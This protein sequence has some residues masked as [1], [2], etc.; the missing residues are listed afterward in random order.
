MNNAVDSVEDFG[1]AVPAVYRDLDA[2]AMK[3][4]SD[5]GGRRIA[6]RIW[7]SGEPLVLLHGS[8]GSWTHWV[9]N[10]AALSGRFRVIAPD[11]PGCGDSDMWPT[12]TSVGELAE[13]LTEGLRQ[14]APD[15]MSFRLCGFSFGAQLAGGMAVRLG[16]AARQLII[17]GSGQIGAPR[18]ERRR[19]ISW[20]KA[21]SRAERLEAHRRNLEIL[22]LHNPVK[23]GDDAV[24]YQAHNAQRSRVKTL[25]LSD[26]PPLK[27]YLEQIQCELA[28]IW[29]AQD[30]A[31]KD[32]FDGYR[33][34]LRVHHP[35]VKFVI[36]PGAAHW[37]AYDQAD[38]FNAAL[39][40]VTG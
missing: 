12:G 29:G 26:N 16:T 7:G 31:S 37:V 3:L 14:I 38:I 2:S 24:W 30:P 21:A 13:A 10:I 5:H 23:P 34:A 27:T 40:E 9:R 25:P 20:R 15:G 22:M 36:I 6:W 8:F 17:V 33:D 35:D 19:L 1:D 39:L 28:G 11:T 18:G 4:H 32:Y